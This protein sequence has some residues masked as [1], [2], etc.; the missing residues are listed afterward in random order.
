MYVNLVYVEMSDTW[1]G[2]FTVV[3]VW[4]IPK[5]TFSTD[6]TVQNEKTVHISHTFITS[7]H[8]EYNKLHLVLRL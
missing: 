5:I 3:F 6:H 8:H 1:V 2:V 7:A 4:T